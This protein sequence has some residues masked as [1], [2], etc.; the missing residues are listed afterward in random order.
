MAEENKTLENESTSSEVKEEKKVSKS[1]F[2]RKEAELQKWKSDCEH[3]KNEY[4][5]AYAD[6]Q[7][8]RKALEKDHHDVIKYR[9]EGFV[10]NLLPILDAF[11]MALGNEQTDPVL[12]NYLIGFQYIYRQLVDVL[13]NEGIEEISPNV[14]DKF[15][16]NLM[17]AVD[18]IE[19]E[20]PA[21]TILKIN[22]KG[23]KLHEHL[24]RPA[25]VI[26]SKAK[27]ESNENEE[28]IN[29]A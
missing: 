24:I 7:N 22:T 28:Q 1:K 20:E 23:Y 10:E 11:H 6:M 19:S 3:W 5:K 8:L 17:Q 21:N 27:E 18:A 14:G 29:K 16:E 25:M 2:E 12:K 4:F 9:I 13:T 15:D 26:V